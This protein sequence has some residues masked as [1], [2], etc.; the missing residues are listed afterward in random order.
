MTKP[1]VFLSYSQQDSER[2]RIL[3]NSLKARGLQVW[4]DR[5]S[6]GAGERWSEA[7]E[8]G[9]RGSRGAVVLITAS[10]ASS[11][12][13]TYEYAF[14][15][16]A[17]IPVVAVKTRGAPIP[18]P[19]K[20]FQLID[21]TD[22]RS[23]AKKIDAGLSS[24]SRALGERRAS[25]PTLVAKFEE[26]NGEP[27]TASRGKTPELWI[28]MWLEQVPKQ[29]TSVAFEISDKAFKDRKWT[30]RRAPRGASVD[31][32]FLCDNMRSYG[33]IEIWASG[34]G[35]GPGNWSGSWRLYE[36][37]MRYYRSRSPSAGVRAA[38]KQIRTN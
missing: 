32:A 7:I 22:P 38:L 20:Q 28:E 27:A 34:I 4:R 18:S 19:I 23:V 14:A 12:W 35:R 33:D 8:R 6:I 24:Q 13:V 11:E 9:I 17:G 3:E 29:T 21:Y 1:A 30:A 36:A 25:T 15:T 16:G 31:R 26:I 2:A 10:S 37:L 5:R